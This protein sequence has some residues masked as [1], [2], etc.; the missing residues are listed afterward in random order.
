MAARE[1]KER[2]EV[3]EVSDCELSE[4]LRR[5]RMDAAEEQTSALLRDLRAIAEGAKRP[6]EDDEDSEAKRRR[7]AEPSSVLCGPGISARVA[8]EDRVLH[9]G[10]AEDFRLR[11]ALSAPGTDSPERP[12]CSPSACGHCCHK[13]WSGTQSRH[14]ARCR[15]HRGGVVLVFTKD[16]ST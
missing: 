13:A 6:R 16:H 8:A 10:V 5:S 7:L 4:A 3:R 9:S 15:D 14:Q 12:E 2:E 1:Q 11:R